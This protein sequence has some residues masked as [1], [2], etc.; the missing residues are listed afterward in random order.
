MLNKLSAN[1]FFHYYALN[2]LSK[3]LSKGD[4][5]K[6]L[7]G[8]ICLG[9]TLGIGH[10]V[11]RL[12]LYDRTI[13]LGSK[14]KEAEKTAKVGG[15]KFG[16][17]SQ[18][19]GVQTNP[20]ADTLGNP[21]AA[22]STSTTREVDAG[23]AGADTAKKAEEE[24]LEEEETEKE[25]TEKLRLEKEAAEKK[26][27]EEPLEEEKAEKEEIEKLRLEKEAAEKKV[28]EER[29][30]QEKAEKEEAAKKEEEQ[31]LIEENRKKAE[32]KER[33][34]QEQKA[35]ELEKAELARRQEEQRRIQQ[36]REEKAEA[37]RAA[38]AK[39]AAENKAK[40]DEF[41]N[42]SPEEKTSKCADMPIEELYDLQK[43]IY[44]ADSDYCLFEDL[45]PAKLKEW[46]IDRENFPFKKGQEQKQFNKIF[47]S[48]IDEKSLKESKIRKLDPKQVEGLWTYFG[49]GQASAIS[50][51]QIKGLDFNLLNRLMSSMYMQKSQRT[52]IITGLFGLSGP[53]KNA[54]RERLEALESDQLKWII[55]DLGQEEFNAISEDQFIDLDLSTVQ[56][57][58]M[59]KLFPSDES[60][61]HPHN[62]S[63][64][65]MRR[66]ALLSQKQFRTIEL[67]PSEVFD[68]RLRIFIMKARGFESIFPEEMQEK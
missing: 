57:N 38:K 24:T 51:E 58:L 8:T 55:S 63:T 47:P 52:G 11:C 26:I 10:A 68:N 30:E 7:I 59:Q 44:E 54:S 60:N 61:E 48:P 4:R 46:V 65:A 1:N 6:A 34:I 20:S 23:K 66:I 29:L 14:S 17:P 62:L 49:G 40:V 9:L 28:E 64:L 15:E 22:A 27:E 67:A 45:P 16:M 50:V 25:D 36:E 39:A 18:G 35:Q 31:R 41:L 12:F 5:V 21:K 56:Y 3:D 19:F 2:P 42:L 33:R 37:E 53:F 13:S 32:E 43:K